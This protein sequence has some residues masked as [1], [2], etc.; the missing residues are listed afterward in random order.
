MASDE[1]TYTDPGLREAV[2]AEVLAGDKGGR[3]GQWSA[4]KAQL[5]AAE[6]KRRGGGY[7]TDKEHEPEAA[8]HLDRWTAEDWQTA[9]GSARAREGDET[10]RY[11]PKEAWDR[12]SPDERAA[13]DRAKREGDGQF[14][15]NTPAA[16]KASQAAR[17]PLERYDDLTVPEVQRA[18]R[19]LD[20]D[21]RERVR[22]YE[23]AHKARKGVLGR[24]G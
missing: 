24:L 16:K 12:L 15:P 3:A 20:D 4:R 5:V 23:S 17:E 2:K 11:L 9:D 1:R 6:Y 14:V 13:T 19:D 18:L 10:A 22:A 21:A 8:R 7:T